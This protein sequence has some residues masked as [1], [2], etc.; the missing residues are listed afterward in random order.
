MY[1]PSIQPA[2]S[3][4][5]FQHYLQHVLNRNLKSLNFKKFSIKFLYKSFKIID[6]LA[7]SLISYLSFFDVVKFSQARF[8]ASFSVTNIAFLIFELQC[9][10]SGKFSSGI[11]SQEFLKNS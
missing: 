9:S 4:R 2:L 10:S 11:Y 6:G 3:G 8:G 1:I 7:L 5:Y